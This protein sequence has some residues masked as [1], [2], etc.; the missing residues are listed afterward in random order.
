MIALIPGL[1]DTLAYLQTPKPAPPPRE[2]GFAQLLASA[3]A[4]EEPAAQTTPSPPARYVVQP[5]DN[6]SRIAKKLG[7]ADPYLL[8]K[9]NNLKD[10][11]VLQVDQVLTL[12]E[13]NQ[14]AEKPAVAQSSQPSATRPAAQ[15]ANPSTGSS[16][17]DRKLV[18]ASWYGP[19]HHGKLM[20]NG[21]P[22][23][24]YADTAAHKKLPLGTRLTLTNPQ[25]GNSVQVEVTDR[26]PFIPGRNI[27]LSYGAAQK[28][29]VVQSGVAKVWMEG[30]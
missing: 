10:A 24:M 16:S 30:G 5:G 25:N 27:D 29:G 28:L 2:E 9:T 6:L 19:R 4:T 17:R 8:A 14:A 20:A 21:E 11:N 18:V 26:G 23:D 12:P 3:A 13:P 22:F 1:T 7:Y 15:S